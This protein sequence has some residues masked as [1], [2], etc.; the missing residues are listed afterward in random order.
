M[1]DRFDPGGEHPTIEWPPRR[2]RSHRGLLAAALILLVLFLTSG[3]SISL[4]VDSLWFSSLGYVRVFWKALDLR[5]GVFLGFAIVTFAVLYT[6]FTAL[7]PRDLGHLSSTNTILINGQ[8]LTFPVA[9]VLK[10]AS[11]VIAAV[12]GLIAGAGLMTEWPTFALYWYGVAGTGLSPDPIFGRPVGFYLF[13]L[14]AWQI[15]IGWLNVL[16]LLIMAAAIFYAVITRRP[17]MPGRGPFPS[18]GGSWRGVSFAFGMLLLVMAGRVYLSR[19]DRLYDTHPI[20]SGVNY[21]DAHIQIPGLLI[22]A[23]ALAAGALLALANAAGRGQL[24]W[25]IVAAAPAVLVYAGVA[26]TAG[27]VSNFIVKPNELVREKP[28]IANN[29]KLT[30]EALG[31]DRIVLHSF[32]AD[33]GTA[34]IDVAHNQETL[35]NVRLWDWQALRDTLRQIQEIRTYYD[36]PQ[37]DI[38]RY[39][40][41]GHERE[42]MLAAR[43][44]NLNKL[45]GS[46]NWINSKLIY[47]HG[48]GV[49][50]NSVNGF[51]PEGLPDLLLSNMPVESAVPSL[52]VTRPQIYYGELT[53]TDVYV[54]THQREFDYPQGQSNSYTTYDGSGGIPIGNFFRRILIAIDRGDLTKLPFSDDVTA[55]SRLLMRRNIM[56]RVQTIAPFLTYDPDP[57][58]VVAPDGHLYWMLDAFTTSDMYPYAQEYQLGDQAINYMRNS[59][60][61]TVDAYNGTVNFYVFE[62]HDPIIEAYT[63]MFPGLFKPESAMPAGLRRHVRYPELLLEVQAAA[64]GLYHMTDPE[65]FYNREDL[66]SVASQTGSGSGDQSSPSPMA[67]NY[68]MMRLPE[69]TDKAVEFVDILPFTPAN[70]NNLIGWIAGRSDGDAYGTAVVYNFPKTRLVDGPLQVE[71]RINQ[72]AELSGQLTL[73]NQQGS[74]VRR[75]DLLVIPIGTGLLY[76]QPIYLQA[77][78]SPMP[79]MRLVVLAL[80]DRVGYGP[81]FQAAMQSLFGVAGTGGSGASGAPSAAPQPAAAPGTPAG[82]ASTASPDVQALIARAAQAFADYQRLTAQG[83]LDEAGAK[84][85]ELKTTLD[86]L[87]TLRPPPQR[88]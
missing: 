1:P 65:V 19:F 11:L 64:Y 71:A 49:T 42:M 17:A 26:L 51:T 21:T 66:W 83:K 8:P 87:N 48:Y 52:T 45:P 15:I 16:A 62:P 78:Q 58:I 68:V 14:P 46:E 25:V 27:Y 30:R 43:E 85:Q 54:R 86:R 50:M 29:I 5:A 18:L 59:V 23:I 79:E 82:P 13:T 9:P 81:T 37:L 36:F 88:H 69:E 2:R 10:L 3:T 77:D 53:N 22:V 40:I 44:L 72:N 31:L 47:T 38:D 75:G 34:A 6:A 4:Y 24:R 76:V 7:R 39:Q 56:R 84:L 60:K 20:F 57:Y 55:N 70:R 61:V 80:Q 33:A 12:A 74:H 73:W 63:R 35:D 41:D 67:P 32:P 28:F